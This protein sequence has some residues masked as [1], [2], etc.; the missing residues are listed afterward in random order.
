M[1]VGSFP[2]SPAQA[3]FSPWLS[4]PFPACCGCT[5]GL[6]SKEG[7]RKAYFKTDLFYA[8]VMKANLFS[9]VQC[10]NGIGQPREETRVTASRSGL[11]PAPLPQLLPSAH[12]P[13]CGGLVQ[14]RAS[15]RG[16]ACSQ[17]SWWKDVVTLPALDD[18]LGF[19]GM[20]PVEESI[21]VCAHERPTQAPPSDVLPASLRHLLRGG[22]QA[23]SWP[24]V[25][26][27]NVSLSLDGPRV[28]CK[29]QR[30]WFGIPW[31]FG[32]DEFEFPGLPT[33]LFTW[34]LL[35]VAPV[36]SVSLCDLPS[37]G[38]S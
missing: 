27:T 30:K 2:G 28:W 6:G 29:G 24:P 34:P 1:G 19:S 37:G 18:P 38:C 13:V 12:R 3:A 22:G 21:E 20:S 9:N 4:A 35:W 16:R 10:P 11:H 17:K 14:P 32:A 33:L 36:A 8:F 23:V 5:P 26:H 25:P 31:S 15:P 7:E